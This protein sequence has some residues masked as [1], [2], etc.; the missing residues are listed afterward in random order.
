MI[1]IK[2]ISETEDKKLEDE[3]NDFIRT[4]EAAD[5]KEFQD[6]RFL[7]AVGPGLV[8]RTAIIFYNDDTKLSEKDKIM[9]CEKCGG[10]T[11]VG[12][13]IGD[14]YHDVCTDCGHFVNP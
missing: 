2:L 9:I 4:V 6:I 12:K 8:T 5:Y 13:L 7:N 11:I 14:E 1:Q 3:I 10:E